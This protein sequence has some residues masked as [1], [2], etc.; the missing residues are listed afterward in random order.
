MPTRTV[1]TKKPMNDQKLKTRQEVARELSVSLRTVDNL[2]ASRAI[3]FIRINGAVR[4]SAAAVA[5]FKQ[6]RTV[7]AHA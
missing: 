1:G 2:I 3:E 7:T 5:K 6:S 4:F